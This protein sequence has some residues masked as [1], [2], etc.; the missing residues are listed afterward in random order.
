MTIT[1][2]LTGLAIAAAIVAI[3]PAAAQAATGAS[4]AVTAGTATQSTTAQ[5]SPAQSAAAK[6][7]GA[8]YAPGKRAKALGVLA[9]TGEDHEV[10]PTA[11]TVRISGKVYDLSRSSSCG[12]AVFRITYRDDTGNLPFKH[13]SILDCSY[14]SPKSFSFTS[15]DVYQVE[16]KVCS[17]RKASKPSLNCLY[18]GSWKTLYLSK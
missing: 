17:E 15:H 3:A 4:D 11:D 7:W 8:Y 1:R 2:T 14:G 6:N 16:L 12:W 5:N 13:R 9:F 18:A 10:I